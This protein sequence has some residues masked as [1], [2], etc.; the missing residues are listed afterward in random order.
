MSHTV[1][2]TE[3]VISALGIVLCGIVFYNAPMW[4]FSLQVIVFSIT[5][6]ILW[7]NARL[8]VKQEQQQR[9]LYSNE[10]VNQFLNESQVVADRLAAA[11][12]EVNLS[13]DRLNEITDHS[14]LHEQQLN[15][16]STLAMER[17]EQAFSSLQQVAAEAEEILN[18]SVHMSQE[19]E[20]TK[21][22]VV[23]VCRS[24]SSTN[25]VMER[26]RT[27]NESMAERTRELTTHAAKIEE[28]NTF[29]REVVAQTSLL[30]LNASIEAARAGEHGR[31]FS[32]VA[33]QIKKLAEQSHDAVERSSTILTSI[34]TGVRQVVDAVKEEKLAVQSGINEMNAMTER[35]DNIFQRIIHVNDMVSKTTDSS[36]HQS[37][38]MMDSTS[39][40]RYVVEVVGNNLTSVEQM[41]AQN[42]KQRNQINRLQNI[43]TN[44]HKVSSELIESISLFGNENVS[45]SLNVNVEQMQRLIENITLQPQIVSLDQD[46]HQEKLNNVMAS[47]QGIEAIWSNRA[48]GTFIYSKPEAGIVNAKGRE[49]WK[50]AMTG[51]I[52][53]SEPYIS[54]ITK[55]PCIT[56][57]KAIVNDEGERVGVVGI[58]LE[59]V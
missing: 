10:V 53:I 57:S 45:H 11:V 27:Y 23:D 48:D 40:I 25:Q 39:M 54:A 51:E 8:A 26:L 33:Q 18:S 6:G 12:E 34:E 17:I 36:K 29:I 21:N 5:T 22:T 2:R 56:L 49:W 28:I 41:L 44:L 1:G 50:K 20:Y 3:V 9:S 42:N 15:Q 30:A 24:L 31:G 43:S 38:L 46:Q 37:G 4:V 35:M 47:T 55:K 58:D 7:R 52:F 59:V 16:S 32:V 14:T 13:I 19:S